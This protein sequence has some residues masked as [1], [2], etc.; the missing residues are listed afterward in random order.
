MKATT[1][2][3]S[4][5]R[6]TDRSRETRAAL[7]PI[8]PTSPRG[9]AGASSP[10]S[11]MPWRRAKNGSVLGASKVTKVT[12]C[13]FAP[14]SLASRLATRSAPPAPR[15]GM[16]KTIRTASLAAQEAEPDVDRVVGVVRAYPFTRR[17]AKTPPQSVV[18]C[19]PQNRVG[20]GV[21][22]LDRNNEPCPALVPAN[23]L[24]RSGRGVGDDGGQSAGHSLQQRVRRSFKTRGHHEELG[25]AQKGERIRDMPDPI[26]APFK[27]ELAGLLSQLVSERP[28]ADQRQAPVR[29]RGGDL[30]PSGKQ[31]IGALLLDQASDGDNGRRGE[32]K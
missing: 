9:S 22:V 11:A 8:L 18:A 4:R 27:A 14:H 1:A 15:L 28:V 20:R 2:S 3:G 17:E 6:N 24:A 7:V 10:R 12:S 30:R 19:E 31:D 23:Q 13:P 5:S 21:R 16:T 32:G 26:N 25:A 29:Q